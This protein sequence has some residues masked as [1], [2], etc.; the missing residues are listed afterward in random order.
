MGKGAPLASS[1]DGYVTCLLATFFVGY[2][3]H[4]DYDKTE[5]SCNIVFNSASSWRCISFR[6]NIT[7][8]STS[9]N[10]SL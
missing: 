5:S 7:Q 1:P 6:K 8:Q 4:T 3:N 9:P 10:I 2:P